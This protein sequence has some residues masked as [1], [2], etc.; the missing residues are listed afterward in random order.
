VSPLGWKA[1][2]IPCASLLLSAAAGLVFVLPALAA[3]LQFDRTAIASGEIWRLFSGHWTH[4]SFDHF[5]WDVSAF[6]LLG[7]ACERKSRARFLVCV[8]ASAFAISS[9]VWFLLPGM[10]AYRGLSGVD[11]ALFVLLAMELCSEGVSSH[12]P[13]EIVIAAVCLAGFLLKISFE[14]VTET[15]VFVENLGS[16]TVGVPLAHVAGAAIGML[17]GLPTPASAS[18][19]GADRGGLSALRS[20]PCDERSLPRI[21]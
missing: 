20:P 8:G 4:Y 21:R 18:C 9:A 13:K 19:S 10:T 12:K 14:L 6:G 5:F 16:G 17:V 11:S 1:R 2:C 3:Q 15:S 7:L